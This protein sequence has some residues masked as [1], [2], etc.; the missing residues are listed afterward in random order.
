MHRYIDLS[1]HVKAAES[2]S[3]FDVNYMQTSADR[4]QAMLDGSTRRGNI[5]FEVE[6]LA[7][8]P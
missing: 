6:Q 8:H 7:C 2:I 4:F 1:A 5:S 3:M